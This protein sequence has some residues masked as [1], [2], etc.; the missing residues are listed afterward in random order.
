VF[1]AWIL[2][3]PNRGNAHVRAKRIACINNLKCLGLA[4]RIYANDHEERFPWQVADTDSGKLVNSAQVFQHFRVA[5]NELSTPKIL[6]CPEDRARSRTNDFEAFGNTN[7]SYFLGFEAKSNAPN[8]FLS[9]DRNISG[10]MLSNGFLRVIT[11]N[12]VVSWTK[13]MHQNVGNIGLADGSAQQLTSPGLTK[14]VAIALQS[15]SIMRLAIP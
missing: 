5:S 7:L 13:D 9:G 1:F 12:S 4:M 3:P 14:A 2:L 8:A 6:W 10:G 11:T 15:N